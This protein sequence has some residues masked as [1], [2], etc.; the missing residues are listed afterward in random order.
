MDTVDQ[1]PD[2]QGFPMPRRCPFEP[3]PEYAGLRAAAPL[4][5]VRLPNGS[6]AWA[7]TR[8]AEAQQV[9]TDPR[10]S[11]D[12]TRPGFPSV[13]PPGAPEPTPEQAEQ[14]A[15]LR[16]GQFVNMDPPEHDTYRRMVI[17]EFSLTR[18]KR[19]RPGI[20]RAVGELI[21]AMLAGER[22]ADL[23]AAFAS[24]VSAAAICELLGVPYADREF[25]QSCTA[26]MLNVHVDPMGA[27][28]AFQELRTYLDDL[29]TAAEKEP[30]DDLIGRLAAQRRSTGELGHDAMVGMVF[31]L[32]V[33][34]HETTA[35]MI[36]LGVL[37]LCEH[38]DQLAAVREDPARWPAAVE[39]LMRFHTVTDW[40]AMD[41]MATE[42]LEVGG[43]AVRAGDGIFV[44]GAS[45]NRDE[46]VF[47][48][49]DEF[50]VGRNA[51]QHLAWGYGV[52]QCIGRNLAQA[53]LEIAYRTLFDR[54]PG[55]RPAVPVDE[56]ACKYDGQIFGLQSFPV[57]W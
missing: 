31:Q 36:P 43:Q 47:D 16:Q 19:L 8:H 34:G 25:F 32:L 30:G 17:S 53:E 54:M 21:D 46:R 28:G 9:L 12:P 15:R 4:V 11:T 55:L 20:E 18:V 48:R 40:A 41:R 37:T 14:L 6:T 24:P 7:V 45:A 44:L 35:N 52:H 51:R 23:V 22:P 10:I 26:R 42:D 33:A 56:L 5:R 29:V 50:D 39:E 49:P 38:P 13:A 3:P 2:A 27:I 1:R 57:T